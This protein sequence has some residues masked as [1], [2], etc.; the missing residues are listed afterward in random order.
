MYIL[1]GTNGQK[2]SISNNELT[3]S[4]TGR[5]FLHTPAQCLDENKKAQPQ[6]ILID[7]ITD[8]SMWN[9]NNQKLK[10]S[11]LNASSQLKPAASNTNSLPSGDM[12]NCRKVS[13]YTDASKKNV[14][15]GY[16]TLDDYKNISPIAVVNPPTPGP[17]ESPGSITT[18]PVVTTPPMT[19]EPIPTSPGATPEP[20]KSTGEI[21]DNYLKSGNASIPPEKFTLLSNA[22]DDD[23][24]S[25]DTSFLYK[26]KTDS[27]LRFYIISIFVIFVYILYRLVQKMK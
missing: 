23:Y 8:N 13:V 4:T 18:E 3:L 6:S 24:D 19:T 22:Y 27:P 2:I 5:Y 7:N 16:V 25:M 26:V 12:E 15:S 21:I 17:S 10:C 1:M 11:L 14:I 9:M 20:T